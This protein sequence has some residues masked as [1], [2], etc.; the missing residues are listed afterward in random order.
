MFTTERNVDDQVIIYPLCI[1]TPLF[2]KSFAIATCPTNTSFCLLGAYFCLFFSF[3]VL[4][5]LCIIDRWFCVEYGDRF[6]DIQGSFVCLCKVR[7][8]LFVP[9][10]VMPYIFK[11]LDLNRLENGSA[12]QIILIGVFS[13]VTSSSTSHTLSSGNS[14]SHLHFVVP[15]GI[16]VSTRSTFLPQEGNTSK[17]SP[18]INSIIVFP[19]LDQCQH[20]IL[21]RSPHLPS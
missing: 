19:M 6:D 8:V 20:G 16:S 17:Q 7:T 3:W 1:L 4:F 9:I 13:N 2:V 10:P 14:T 18:L 12:P 21:K 11:L 15:Y 5:F